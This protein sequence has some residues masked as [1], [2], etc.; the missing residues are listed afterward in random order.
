MT[1]EVDKPCIRECGRPRA[2]GK[3]RCA[4]CLEKQRVANRRAYNARVRSGQCVFCSQRATVG[5]FCRDHWFKNVGVP[6]GLGNKKGQ[7]ILR[8]LWE[9]QQ[10][11]CAVTG[12]PMSPGSTASL[13]HIVP[14]SRGGLSEKG[15]LRWVLLRINQMKW[16]MTNDEFVQ[17]CR[18]VVG[19][20]D[21]RAKALNDKS[22]RSN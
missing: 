22:M 7:A 5:A 12:R 10:G 20:S 2:A 19:A 13:D 3:S 9:E 16:D 21:R 11:C 15:N 6:H 17:I 18:V 1:V 8:E 4:V 14:K